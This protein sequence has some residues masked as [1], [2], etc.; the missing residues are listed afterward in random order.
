MSA[1]GLAGVGAS[2]VS[3]LSP[4]SIIG[5]GAG[6]LKAAPGAVKKGAK[7]AGGLLGGAGYGGFSAAGHDQDIGEGALMV[8]LLVRVASF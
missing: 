1:S 8:P 7:Y 5:K 2:A 4:A 6:L 3:L